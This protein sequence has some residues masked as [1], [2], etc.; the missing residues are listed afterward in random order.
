MKI[1]DEGHIYE[2]DTI[3][4]ADFYKQTIV[5]VK[6]NDPSDKY[7]GN[8]T[9]FPGV[10]S[11]EVIRVLIDRVKY[12]DN[13]QPCEENIEILW[14]LR[15]SIE[16]F[17]ERTHRIHNKEFPNINIDTIESYTPCP[18]CGHILCTWCNNE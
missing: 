11:Q 9:S 5:F 4:G 7:P 6:R 8:N 14:H 18:K 13:Q 1:L 10:L 16:Y 12:L 3:D 2:M 17:E 15:A